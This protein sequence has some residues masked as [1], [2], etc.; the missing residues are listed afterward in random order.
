M[1]LEASPKPAKKCHL[2]PLS[3]DTYSTRAG[4]LAG[5]GGAAGLNGYSS[6]NAGLESGWLLTRYS[7]R[8]VHRPDFSF[9]SARGR[10]GQPG[11]WTQYGDWGQA[12]AR[13]FVRA[14]PGNPR[15]K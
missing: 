8:S 14:F 12:E 1:A 11:P 4:D 7:R 9:P 15:L 13:W 2:V 3:R 6:R 5:R 10:A